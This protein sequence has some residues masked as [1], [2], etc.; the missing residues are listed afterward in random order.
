VNV[1]DVGDDWPA[2]AIVRAVNVAAHDLLHTSS[3][4]T[5]MEG[6]WEEFRG[7]SAGA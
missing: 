6:Y 1:L 3:R 2:D 7:T 5:T 4:L